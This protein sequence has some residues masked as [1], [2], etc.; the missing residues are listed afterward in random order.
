MAKSVVSCLLKS[1]ERWRLLSR[2]VLVS[3]LLGLAA[4]SST[5]PSNTNDLCQIFDE[6][7]DWYEDALASSK[8][9]KSSIPVMM[10]IMKQESGFREDAKPPRTKIL[11]VIPGPR[12]SSA[13]GYAQVKDGTWDWYKKSAGGWGSDRDDFDDAI[14]FVGWYNHQ[15]YKINKISK[16]DAYR[17]YLA[18]HEG[19]GGFKRKTYNKKSWLIGVAKKVSRQAKRYQQQLKKCESRL[20]SGGWFF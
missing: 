13:Y 9:W 12:K 5:P 8:K 10:A 2:L 4:C 15:S 6:K 17:L 18:Y 11:W 19:H 3:A 16:S 14:D 7:D 20:D 1:A